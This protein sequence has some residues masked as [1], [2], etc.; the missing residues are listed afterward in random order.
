LAEELT[1]SAIV[2]GSGADAAIGRLSPGSTSERLLHGAPCPVA[3]AP[4]GYRF[5]EV[6]A[7]VRTVAVAYVDSD[8]GREALELA[9]SI[10]QRTGAHL[11][12]LTVTERPES[13]ASEQ[14]A[15]EAAEAAPGLASS[16][17]VLTGRDVAAALA[18]RSEHEID[19]LVCGSRGYGPVRSV[20]LGGVSRRLVRTA[21]CPVLIVPR[22]GPRPS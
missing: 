11:L 20:L 17:E 12:V 19:L 6:D 16:V 3:V 14:L 2:V 18:K 13:V 15:N 1:A 8:E 10:G 7:T 22:G 4:R 5:R 21:A 9:A